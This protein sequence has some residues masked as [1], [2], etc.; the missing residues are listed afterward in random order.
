M[1]RPPEADGEA[2]GRTICFLYMAKPRSPAFSRFARACLPVAALSLCFGALL[3]GVCRA[4]PAIPEPVELSQPDGAKV[5]IA[6][7]GDEFHHWHEDDKGYTVLKDPATRNWVYA[8][9]D[10]SGT[11]KAGKLKVGAGDPAKTGLQK[12]MLDA[13]AV[14]SA[15]TRRNT[16]DSSARFR[17]MGKRTLGGGQAPHIVSIPAS[18]MKN[19]VILV[20]FPAA[21]GYPALPHTYT[22]AQFDGLFNTAGYTDGG[23]VG[24]VKDYYKEV[25]YNKL[26]IQSTV[27][28]WVT[29]SHGYGWYGANNASGN[30]MKPREMVRE[31]V[32]L[33]EAAGFDFAGMDGN[34]DGQLDGLAVIHAGM[35]EENSGND[36][37]YIWSHQWD[38]SSGGLSV[39]YDGVTIDMYHTEPEVRGWADYP[40]TQGLARIGVICHETGHF[41]GLP[42]LYDY[43]NDSEGAGN[44]CLMAG[45]SWN[46][47]SGT[48]PAHLSAW[49]KK[50][51]GWATA[52]P[53]AYG[54]NSLA[55]IEVSDTALFSMRNDSFPT[56]EYFLME[57]RQGYG[58][59]SGLPGTGR[60]IL[61]WH[62]DESKLWNGNNDDQSHYLVDLE[63]AGGTQHLE[64]NTN[65]G[66]DFDYYRSGNNTSF[67]DSTDPNS[68]SYYGYSLFRPIQSISAA[69]NTMTF[70]MPDLTNPA[71][72]ATVYD[73]ATAGSDIPKTGFSTQLSANW[74]ASGDPETGIKAYW[75]A[76]GTSAGATNTRGWTN[77]GTLTSVTATSL[78]LINGVTYYFSV[79]AVNGL[80]M[81]STVTSSNGQWVDIAMPGAVPCVYDGTGADI[82]YGRSLGALSAN[83]GASASDNIARYWYGI[84][85]SAGAT[86][87]LG[88]TDNALSLSVTRTGL[89]LLEGVTYYFAVKAQND[90]GYDSAV[91]VS[92]GQRVDVTSPTARVLITSPVP[93]K[94]GAMAVKLITTEAGGLSGNPALSFVTSGGSTRTIALTFLA[95]STW[96]GTAYIESYYS[97]GTANFSFS[98]AD[99]VGNAGSLITSGGA[100]VI[101]T[102]VSGTSGGTVANSD[103]TTV[104]V[105]AGAYDGS[106]FISISTVTPLRTSAADAAT[107]DSY[108]IYTNGSLTREFRAVDA[109]TGVSV[110]S[111]SFP[112]TI[113]IYYPDAD[114]DGRIDSN[115]LMENL[116][117]FY[118][119]DETRNVW[120]RL[121]DAVQSESANYFTLSTSHFSIYTIR[122]LDLAGY[123]MSGLT[124]WPNPCYPDRSPYKLYIDGIPLAASAPK[125]YIYNTAGEL[126]RTLS[127]GD[128]IY[129]VNGVKKRAEWN[130]KLKNGSKAASGLYMYV[131]KTANYGKAGGKF[132]I[133]Q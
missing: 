30:D 128:G 131:L 126:V 132:Y 130:G 129:A 55:R 110:S 102:S 94:T 9:K 38:L 74:T 50:Y 122:S 34:S 7:K 13:K 107:H 62:V 133:F 78:S 33:L 80:D 120:T 73:G 22:Q 124:A 76:I 51:L 91:T 75:Y 5:R 8:E 25:S 64:A 66:D 101:D 49:C 114:N 63:E 29:L 96:T 118:V 71:S 3:P 52:T 108:P 16:R 95:A 54:S 42:D 105:P 111:F 2:E 57:N 44:F 45:G 43:D 11:L 83:W 6:L 65:A 121:T 31:A 40:S 58:F 36:E 59:D 92:N 10:A 67:T 103:T 104:M 12:H 116:A 46:G 99:V 72:I 81:E 27:Y 56:T 23:A 21:D 85:T 82:T 93:V 41:L 19:L 26:D 15:R 32:D 87:T 115:Y 90:M 86:D 48:S 35:G 79:K 112:L 28:A 61:I 113:T 39:T 20:E 117:R 37:D 100:F 18:P 89:S 98:A 4:V 125:A 53:V 60:G 106:L 17:V 77:N 127:E 68:L 24:S 1:T 84:G 97:T 109:V 88:W 69:G 119:L 123:S 70:Q 14:G 47:N